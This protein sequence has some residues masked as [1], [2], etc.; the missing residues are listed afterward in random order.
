MKRIFYPILLLAL[1][2]CK[3]TKQTSE[4]ATT[5]PSIAKVQTDTTATQV[6]GI[7]SAT[8]KPNQVSFNGTIV[9]SPQRQ[10]TVALTMGGVVRNTSLLPGQQVQKGT[11]LATLENPDFI[12]L[13]QTYLDSHAQTEYLQ[14]EYE[15]QKSLSA[16]QAASQKKF[17]QS[18]ADYLSMKSK[19]EATAAQLSLLGITPEELLKSGIQPLLQVKA[20]ISGYISDVTMNIGKYIQPGEALCEV[21]DKSS[22]LLCLT[23][24][25]KDLTDMKVG[26]PVQFRVNGMGK[27]VFKATLVSIGQKVDETSRSLEVYARID[28]T[29]PQFRPGMYVT[30]R[31]QK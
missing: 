23:T 27:T 22:P 11:L 20:P 30:A 26:S 24:Y 6:D 18:K 1:I 29:A 19:L 4:T 7:T 21:I 28:S 13:Q 25:E 16:E 9:L 5:A 8:S 15:R 31:I 3:E 14:A 17:Q 12:M 2:A 10:A